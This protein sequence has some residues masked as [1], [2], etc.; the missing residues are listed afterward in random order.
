MKP[1]QTDMRYQVEGGGAVQDSN[2][3]TLREARRVAKAL[4]AKGCQGVQIARYD[5]SGASNYY[6]I[7]ETL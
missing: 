4:K 1:R 2:C 6:E 5:H 7:V 3:S